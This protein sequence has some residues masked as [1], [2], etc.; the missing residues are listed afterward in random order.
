MNAVDEFEPDGSDLRRPAGPCGKQLRS[1]PPTGT[2][3][4]KSGD[5]LF[6]LTVA[7][8]LGGCHSPDF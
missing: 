7:S 4:A 1:W 2:G 6:H 5:L 3:G 8:G